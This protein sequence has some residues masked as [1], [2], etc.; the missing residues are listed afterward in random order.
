MP[1]EVL[2]RWKTEQLGWLK[3]E[4]WQMGPEESLP[5]FEQLP[6]TLR[7]KFGKFRDRAWHGHLDSCFGE[8]LLRRRD[9][10]EIVFNSLNHFNTERYDLD[11]LVIMPNH[12]HVLVQFRAPITCR[13][14]T[15]SWL[16]YSAR[17]INRHSGRKG[18]FWQGE[19]FDHLVR[20][21][22]QFDYLRWYIAENGRKANLPDSEYL[23]WKA[24][25]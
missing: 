20:T 5:D 3:S 4:G 11:S 12:V 19:P 22:E 6:M 8:C 13:A 7:K 16:R 23:Y 15:E 9:F 2:L 1:R 21:P 18:A 10:A 25:N 24:E 14:Q 17:E